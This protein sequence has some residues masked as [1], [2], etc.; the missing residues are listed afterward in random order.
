MIKL[1]HIVASFSLLLAATTAH[2]A[3]ISIANVEPNAEL[4]W[5]SSIHTSPKK[6]V[7]QDVITAP[8][9]DERE[10][11]RIR[12]QDESAYDSA[13]TIKGFWKTSS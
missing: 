9:F 13:D 7:G 5:M 1:L 11:Q 3:P 2:S 4:G 12:S 10:F 6:Q 8:V